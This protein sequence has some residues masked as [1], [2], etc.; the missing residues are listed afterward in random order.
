L[1]YVACFVSCTLGLHPA[2][3]IPHFVYMVIN[4]Y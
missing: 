1:G 2:V 3:C 4:Q